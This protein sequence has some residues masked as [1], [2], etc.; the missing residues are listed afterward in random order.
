MNS[1]EISFSQEKD[2]FLVHMKV[3]MKKKDCI[4]QKKRCFLKKGDRA[5]HLL[6]QTY[7]HAHTHT[8]KAKYMK[9]V[10]RKKSF[11]RDK[12]ENN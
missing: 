1:W 2:D 3:E 8:G 9:K 6:K 11:S 12:G 5:L 7:T 4:T 10:S